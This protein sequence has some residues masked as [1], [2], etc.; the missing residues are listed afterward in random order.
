MRAFWVT[1]LAFIAGPIWA[2]VNARNGVSITTSSVINGVTGP[3][4]VN[5]QTVASGGYDPDASAFF[6]RVV[7]NGGTIGTT[8]KNAVNDFVLAAKANGYWSKLTRI[9][10]IVGD[11]L[12][13]ALTPLKVGGGSDPETNN[14]FVSGDYTQSTGLTGNGSTKWLNTGLAMASYT[15]A[16]MAVYAGGLETSGDTASM[17]EYAGSGASGMILNNYVSAWGARAFRGGNI[18]QTS[19][20]QIS[21]GLITGGFLVGNMESGPASYIYQN[22]SAS[23]F[24]NS[25]VQSTS[26][27]AVGIFAVNIAGSASGYSSMACRGYSIGST[28]TSTD[29][30]NMNTDLEAFQDALGRGLQ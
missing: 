14:N 10:L 5:G 4:A 15:N 17:G 22:G 27:V 20:A 1:I 16:H 26:G 11:Q 6:A 7:T 24:Q 12:A 29:I 18:N 25:D 9:N 30:G 8:A 21:S 19:S 3:S 13:A 28:L 2:D 23:N